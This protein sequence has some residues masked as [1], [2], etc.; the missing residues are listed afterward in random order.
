MSPSK[1][2]SVA[3]VS[4]IGVDRTDKFPFK[5]LNSFKVLDMKK[6]AENI[7][8]S[9]SA[10]LSYKAIV[11]RPGRLVGAPYTNN[12]VAKLFQTVQANNNRNLQFSR[13]DDVQGDVDRS[14][15]AES[16]LRIMDIPSSQ[17]ENV[18]YSLVNT[19]GPS[20]KE[21]DWD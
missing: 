12:D 20:P 9:R 19:K 5:I 18:V 1:V 3:M 17:R 7:L 13:L 14:D 21:Q 8:L 2:Q 15:V 16:L 6:Q 10:E 4:S 11:V